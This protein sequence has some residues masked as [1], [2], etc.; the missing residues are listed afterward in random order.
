MERR[1]TIYDD[2]S[3][4]PFEVFRRGE[5]FVSDDERAWLRFVR[6]AE[7]LLGHS[8]DGNQKTDGY[9]LDVAHDAF[10]NGDIGVEDYVSEVREGVGY[11]EKF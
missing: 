10:A 7:K 2:L 8:L 6:K 1:M 5:S 4:H 3:E 9:S 11:G